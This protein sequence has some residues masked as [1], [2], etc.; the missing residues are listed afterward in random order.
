MTRLATFALVI[1]ILLLVACAGRKDL[2]AP[3]PGAAAI[4]VSIARAAVRTV[5]AAFEETGTFIADETSDI[6]PLI[7]GRAASTPV[8]I[9]DFVKQGQIVCE[10]DHRDAQ[11][12]LDQARAQLEQATSAVRQSESRLGLNGSAAFDAKAV[13]E[14][15]A[16]RA[17]YESAQA[18]ARLAAADAKRYENLVATGDVSRSAYERART[19]Q[20][21]AEAQANAAH[22]QYEAALNGA[23]QGWGGVQLS[24]AGLNA[25]RAQLAQAQKALDDT[26]LRAPFDGH[27]TARPVAVGNYVAVGTKV[28][29]IVRMSVLKLHLQSPEQRAAGAR[30]GMT[31][32]A[33][34]SAYPDRDFTGKIIAINPSVDPSSRVFIIEAR[35]DNPGG[36][37]RPGM[38]ATA[39]VLLPGGQDAVFVPST[40]VVRDRTTDSYQ[41]FTIE[42]GKARLRTVVVGDADGGSTRI[43]SGLDGH[44][45][46]ATGNLGE[47]YDGAAVRGRT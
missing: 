26:T 11:L 31:V 39:R 12:R 18:Q 28:A 32:Q 25:A 19:Q 35:F 40:A 7:A 47:L 13:P 1:A 42:N 38:F 8:D 14:V 6:A 24:Q 29:T 46:V 43:A 41:V 45:T 20:E 4:S 16:A 30:I 10:L 34:V 36:Q 27:V 17:N 33:R 9:G 5:P 15:A 2:Q 23:R 37:L 3:A 44:E 21:T 22:Q